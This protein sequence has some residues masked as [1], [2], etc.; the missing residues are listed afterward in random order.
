M[1]NLQTEEQECGAAMGYTVKSIAYQFKGS[2][3]EENGTKPSILSRV[4]NKANNAESEQTKSTSYESYSKDIMEDKNN[5]SITKPINQAEN[6]TNNTNN[7]NNTVTNDIKEQNKVSGARKAFNVGKEFMN[8]GMYM[9][10][11]KKF[12]K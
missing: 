9:A 1:K 2:N 5:I 3:A 10:E 12:Q 4:I 6:I 7:V 8:F 11:R